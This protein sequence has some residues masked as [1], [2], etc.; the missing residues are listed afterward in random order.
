MTT[1]TPTVFVVDDDPSVR[2]SMTAALTHRGLN[3]E[4]FESAQSFLRSHASDRPGCLVLDLVMPGMGG[5]ELQ[6]ELAA[7]GKMIPIIFMTGSGDVPQSVQA[8]KAGAIDFLEKPFRQEI[9]LERIQDALAHDARLRRDK[10]DEMEY[11][12]RFSRLTD[13][14][15]DVARLLVSGPANL[16][17]K[18]IARELGIS[19]R[20]VDQYRA[21]VMDKTG[22]RSVAELVKLVALAGYASPHKE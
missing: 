20:T 12:A 6:R 1:Q 4:T 18:E 16:S 21:R 13:R 10:K 5:L 22:A 11:Q 15:R 9:L 8:V 2:K 7:Q 14:E 19:H 17:S 3:V